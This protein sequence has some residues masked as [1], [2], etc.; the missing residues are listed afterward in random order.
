MLESCKTL[1]FHAKMEVEVVILR[2]PTYRELVI[3]DAVLGGKKYF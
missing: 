1:N 2:V 3:K